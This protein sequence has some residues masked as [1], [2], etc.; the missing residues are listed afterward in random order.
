MI[1]LFVTGDIHLCRKYSSPNIGELLY[2]SRFNSLQNM[3]QM[4]NDEGC[5]F[6]VITGDLFDR[7]SNISKEEIERTVKIL[8]E[9]NE[10]VL[11]LPG[12]HDYYTPSVKLWKDFSHVAASAPNIFLLNKFEN[13]AEGLSER[14]VFFPAFCDSKKSNSNRLKW[15]ADN[16][17]VNDD[18][19]NVGIV[20]GTL[21]GIT[22]DPKGEYFPMSITELN[23]IPMDVWLVGHTHITYPYELSYEKPFSGYSIFNAGSHEPLDIGE[24]TPGNAIL[25]ALDRDENGSKRVFARKIRTGQIGYQD[26]SYDIKPTDQRSLDAILSELTKAFEKNTVVRIRLSGMIGPNDYQNKEP[27]YEY[28]LSKYLD[29]IV[30][31]DDLVET[32]TI[33]RIRDEYSEKSLAAHFLERLIDDP[34]EL[35][36]AYKL[37]QKCKGNKREGN[38]NE[39]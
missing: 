6:F 31:D 10:T 27:I 35:Q 26:I 36:L 21:R 1:N 39:D 17:P 5:S 2:Q 7:I 34:I 29:H 3:V 9:F 14:I 32:I 23:S 37:L 20:H 12:N 13:Y 25:I 24:R 30:V 4:A 16:P 8:S 15:I 38:E 33:D 11:V 18:S 19:F 22:P 28:A